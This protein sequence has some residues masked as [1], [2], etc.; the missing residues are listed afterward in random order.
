MKIIK[1]T[2]AFILDVVPSWTELS[3]IAVRLGTFI[4]AYFSLMAAFMVG[5]TVAGFA[6]T[7]GLMFAVIPFMIFT[8]ARLSGAIAKR[9]KR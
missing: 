2:I 6:V 9:I 8:A 7:F 1:K 4:M 5:M 3:N